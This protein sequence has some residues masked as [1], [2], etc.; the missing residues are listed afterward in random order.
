MLAL[1]P[2]IIP[3]PPEHYRDP[4]HIGGVRLAT[5]FTLAPLAGYTTKSAI[6]AFISLA[7]KC[8]V[9]SALLPASNTIE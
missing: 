9:A 8:H 5:R 4:L 7:G 6:G 1:A 2:N 3:A